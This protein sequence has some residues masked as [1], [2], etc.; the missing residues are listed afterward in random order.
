MT[1]D[2]QFKVFNINQD[3]PHPSFDSIIASPSPSLTPLGNSDFLLEVTDSFLA[4]DSIPSGINNEIFYAEG[5]ILLLE[6][7]LNINSTKDLPPQELNNDSERYILFLEK[8]LE[9]EPSEAK[10]SEIDPLI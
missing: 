1:L 9:D 10:K 8:L 4:L 2:T 6:K 5:D 3:Q 7:L